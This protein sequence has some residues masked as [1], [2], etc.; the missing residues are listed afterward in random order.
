M[1]MGVPLLPMVILSVATIP[2]LGLLFIFQKYIPSLMLLILFLSVFIWMRITTKHDAWRTKQEVLRFRMRYRKGNP[3][4]WGGMS[5]APFKLRPMNLLSLCAFIA[6]SP[7]PKDASALD[8]SQR[9]NAKAPP[10]A[11]AP[12]PLALP[13]VGTLE[14]AFSPNEGS[15]ELVIK[16]IKSARNEIRILAYSFTSPAVVSALLNAKQK[17]IDI[18]VVA[19]SKNNITQDSSGKAR[20]ALS[21]LVNSGIDVRTIGAYSIH[22]D[23][24]IITDRETVEVGSFNYSSGAAL[25]NSEN[26]LVNWHN[27]QLAAA[28]L[29]HFQ[30]NYAQATP[31]R[32]RY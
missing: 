6:I 18:K 11:T 8:L 5:Y 31:Y 32:A 24:V 2:P 1:F 26:V 15:E 22:H 12:A 25:R 23:K 4:I 28:Y 14:V 21:A 20:A 7:Y 9:F 27:P 19:D 17:G 10:T 30:R 29:K 16:V 3:Q 13:A